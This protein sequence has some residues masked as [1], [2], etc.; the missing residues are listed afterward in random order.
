MGLV[1]SGSKRGRHKQMEVTKM[2]DEIKQ[3][4]VA[5]AVAPAEETRGNR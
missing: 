4:A 5:E 1:V 3:E 2:S